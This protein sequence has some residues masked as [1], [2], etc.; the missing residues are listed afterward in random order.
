VCHP[1]TG[2]IS[3][4]CWVVVYSPQIWENYQLKSGEG[5]SVAF[6]VLWLIGDLTNLAGG[7]MAHLLPTMVSRTGEY[8]V[9]H[10]GPVGDQEYS[11]DFGLISC[12]VDQ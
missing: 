9:G 3:I 7:V 4:A 2:W 11:T 10:V 12:W 6:I 8:V 1:S 5:L